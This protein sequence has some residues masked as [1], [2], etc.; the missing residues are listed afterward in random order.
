MYPY[1]LAEN[2]Y[3]SSPTPTM[4]DARILGGK[5]HKE[6]KAAVLSCIEDLYTKTND[7]KATDKDFRLVT[8]IQDVGSGKTHLA[9]HIRGSK[10]VSEHCVISYMD[11]S[12]IAPRSMN[13]VYCS[14]MNGFAA[15]DISLLR[16]ALVNFLIEKANDNVKN[17]KKIFKY[18]IFDK[19]SGKT[20]K[21]KADDVLQRRLLPNYFAFDEFLKSEFTPTEVSI[22]KSLLEGTYRRDSNNVVTLEDM[23]TDLTAIASLN[24][25]FLG[26]VTIFE[27]DEFDCDTESVDFAKAVINVHIPG[28]IVMLILT[29][30]SYQEIRQNSIS[31]F[32]RLEKA[33]YKIDLAG[34]NSSEEVADIILE[35][36]RFFDYEKCFAADKERDLTSKIKVIYD[37]FSD[38]RNVRSMINIFHHAT[39]KA[40]KTNTEVIDEQALDETIKSTYPGLKIKGSIMGIPL[41]DFIKI[42]QNCS[43]IQTLESGVR[44]AIRNLVNYVQDTSTITQLESS[45]GENACTDLV[46][47]DT[48][49]AKVAVAVV[50]NKDRTK[51]IEQISNRIKSTSFVDKLVILTNYG[52][53]SG[54]NGTTVVNID[55]SKMIDL[56]Y[57]NHKYES[58]L[59]LEEEDLQRALLLAQSIKL[60]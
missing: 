8:I 25:R 45:V 35:Y 24:L 50:I 12:Q 41:S 5:R 27:I 10:E 44:Y 38:F 19:L 39:E 3:P 9:L 4:L 54:M 23:I 60:C 48:Y 47:H 52:T 6:A 15:E 46:Y 36:I 16:R 22:L 43:D 7:R 13:A 14:M 37:E 29:P 40:G 11:L 51:N 42:R 1:K 34:S 21:D 32:D 31:L 58:N 20:L 53:S 57:F 26:K 28:S 2:P 56:M 49:G 55:R 18:G 17:A 59:I 30:S 33:N